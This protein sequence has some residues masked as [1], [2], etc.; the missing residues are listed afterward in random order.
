MTDNQERI[1]RHYATDDYLRIRQETHDKYTVP[2]V[3]FAD[4]ALQ[5]LTWRGDET[6]LDVGCGNGLYYGKLLA[7]HPHVRYVGIDYNAVMLNKHPA[8][9][10]R[11][12]RGDATKLPFADGQFDVVMA[13]HVLFL[14]SDIDSAIREMRRVLKPDGVLMAAT[15]SVQTMP[16]MQVL[17]RRAIVLLTRNGAANVRPPANPSDAFALENGTRFLARYFYAVVRH[18]LPS[19]LVFPDTEPAMAYLE[20]MRDLREPQLPPDVLWD[21]VMM[22]MRQQISQLVKHLGELVINKQSGVL[23]ATNSGGFIRPYLDKQANK[24]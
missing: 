2:N 5:C 17:M 14:I 13:N 19:A 22:I 18:D 15:N 12:V 23:I 3:N 11:L 6:V 21:D 10:G 4:W 16:E 8:P 7:R 1:K 20:S 24:G 9:R